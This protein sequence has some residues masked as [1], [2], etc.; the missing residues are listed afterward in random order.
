MED[1][2]YDEIGDDEADSCKD[3]LA[4]AASAMSEAGAAAARAVTRRRQVGMKK[5][6]QVEQRN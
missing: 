2:A 6:P 4:I 1:V 5:R 3:S